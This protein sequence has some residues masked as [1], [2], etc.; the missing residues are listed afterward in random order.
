[1]DTDNYIKEANLQL[2][3]KNN[4]KTLQ[5]NPSLQHNKTVNDTTDQFKKRKSL[6]K[7]TT[8]V[9]KL[10]NSKTPKFYIA[11]KIHK[12]NNHWRPVINSVN[13]HT[14]EISTMLTITFNL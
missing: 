14:S 5:T 4:Y 8:E 11:P 9:L 1:M 12:E 10:I 7:K 3:D 2:S 6:Q 13:C